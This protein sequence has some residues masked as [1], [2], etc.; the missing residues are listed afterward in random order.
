M[1]DENKKHVPMVVAGTNANGEGDFLFI[2]VE[3]SP[4]E[5]SLGYHY[6]YAQEKAIDAGFDGDDIVCY[7]P[8]EMPAFR[9]ITEEIAYHSQEIELAAEW[10]ANIP[11]Q[12]TSRAA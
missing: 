12:S 2:H 3:V 7:D 6:D 11:S 8:S 9:R 5:Y 10:T 1:F 4:E